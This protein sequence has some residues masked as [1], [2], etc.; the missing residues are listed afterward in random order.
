MKNYNLGR[1]IRRA[2]K[3]Y[4]FNISCDGSHTLTWGEAL[5]ASWHEEKNS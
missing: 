4:D 3:I 5:N 1:I 2:K